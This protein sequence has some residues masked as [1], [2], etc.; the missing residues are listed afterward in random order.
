[1]EASYIIPPIDFTTEYRW[2]YND[3]GH[4][5]MCVSNSADFPAEGKF[6]VVSREIYD[7]PHRFTIKNQV[8]ELNKTDGIQLT[9]PLKKGTTG[10]AVVKN[11]AS[12]LIEDD[13][14]YNLV[15]Y[16]EYRNS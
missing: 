5:I 12:L 11:N 1:M 14:Q 15:E 9:A 16:Y 10:F 4:V 2:Y 7:L 6:I 13:E 8:P 3:N